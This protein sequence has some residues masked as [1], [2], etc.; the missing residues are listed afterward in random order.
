MQQRVISE[1]PP[2]V[3]VAEALAFASK[4]SDMGC[5]EVGS[6]ELPIEWE[7]ADIIRKL[8]QQL[9]GEQASFAIEH[10]QVLTLRAKLDRA[11]DR[12]GVAQG[13]GQ[14]EWV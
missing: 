4:L 11:L 14:S 12:L 7:A 2:S 5:Y 6:G 13:P 1:K 8:V 9:A 10:A 3:T